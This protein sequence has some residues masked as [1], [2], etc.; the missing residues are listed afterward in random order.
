VEVYR[1]LH[2]G[3]KSVAERVESVGAAPGEGRSAGP[4]STR[5]YRSGL[6]P[7]AVVGRIPRGVRPV[8]SP[9]E[10]RPL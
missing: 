6:R 3:G 9:R 2:H 4:C 1:R 10:G 8:V 7:G 5:R